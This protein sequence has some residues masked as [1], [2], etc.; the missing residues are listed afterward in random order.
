MN[1]KVI[2]MNKL[3]LW[4][5]VL[6]TIFMTGCS[7]YSKRL[8]SSVLENKL[9]GDIT[10]GEFNYG[11]MQMVQQ[12]LQ[13]ALKADGGDAPFIYEQLLDGYAS[14][15][16]DFERAILTA[17][18]I[19]YLEQGKLGDFNYSSKRLQQ[20]INEDVMITP[21][22]QYVLEISHAMNAMPYKGR[23]YDPRLRQVINNILQ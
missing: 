22:M 5:L 20:L 18:S 12:K 11:P 7:N 15:E 3:I 6:V 8:D 23:N 21:A 1:L 19:E 2:Q 10:L 13:Q 9:V 4:F 14:P 17:L 16:G